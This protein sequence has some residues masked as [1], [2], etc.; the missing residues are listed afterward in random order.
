MAAAESHH[1][2]GWELHSKEHYALS[3]YLAGLSVECVFRAYRTRFD[4]EFDSRHDLFRLFEAA[5]FSE[6]LPSKPDS[7][8][9]YMTA[10][11]YVATYWS[12]KYRF[13]SAS[14]LL[15]HLKRME[16]YLIVKSKGGDLLKNSSR[17]ML[18]EADLLVSLGAEK[19]AS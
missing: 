6:V 18:T 3:H 7:Y 12:N 17:R 15:S 16:V 4:P 2:V 11:N 13:C 9:K 19:W 10:L 5:K 1:A 8:E 14:R